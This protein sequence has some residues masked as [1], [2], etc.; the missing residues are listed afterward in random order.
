[1]FSSFEQRNFKSEELKLSCFCYN[2]LGFVESPGDLKRHAVTQGMLQG[3]A[4]IKKN[5]QVK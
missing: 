5:S 2:Q 4:D 1:M 3:R